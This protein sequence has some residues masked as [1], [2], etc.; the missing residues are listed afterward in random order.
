MHV[1]VDPHATHGLVAAPIAATWRIVASP[2]MTPEALRQQRLQLGLS[3]AALAQALGVARN[4]VARWER[5][6]LEIRHPELIQMALDRLKG[7]SEPSVGAP[8]RG[9]LAAVHNL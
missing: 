3:Q 4:T 5:S 9:A 6:K 2:S 8:T 1:E 7:G